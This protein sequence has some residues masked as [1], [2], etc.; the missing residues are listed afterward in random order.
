MDVT[1]TIPSNVDGALKE[2]AMFTSLS[3][4]FLHVFLMG[5]TNEILVFIVSI[6]LCTGLDTISSYS[7]V[8]KHIVQ[9]MPSA[10]TVA[11]LVHF[12][13][14]I[15]DNSMQPSPGTRPERHNV[16][17]IRN[18]IFCVVVMS[19]C[20]RRILEIIVSF[21]LFRAN[22]KNATHHYPTTT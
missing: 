20:L 15:V 9:V 1:M 12:S 4:F 8:A 21:I 19:W 14:E 16:S 5:F 3:L 7:F 13:S 17:R 22:V 10:T 18:S 2:M 6:T 11:F